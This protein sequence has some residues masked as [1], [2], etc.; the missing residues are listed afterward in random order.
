MR[1]A[2]VIIYIISVISFIYIIYCL[3]KKKIKLS[4][5]F[6]PGILFY[7]L[8]IFI[9]TFIVLDTNY[10]EWDEFSHWGANLK[11]MVQHNLFWSNNIYDGV[12]VVYP[13][14]AGLVEYFFAK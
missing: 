13:P 5:I 6:T 8:T 10:Y 14:L 11:A 2:V 1:F 4:Q 9:M 12:H 7:I 3:I